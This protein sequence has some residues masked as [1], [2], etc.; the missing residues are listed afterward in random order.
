[1]WNGFAVAPG[2]VLG[3]AEIQQQPGVVGDSLGQLGVDLSREL[4]V[5]LGHGLFAALCFGGQ[6][7]RLRG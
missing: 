4:E 7:G 2:H 6:V 3:H 5:S 1:V